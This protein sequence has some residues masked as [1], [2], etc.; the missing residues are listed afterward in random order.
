MVNRSL[1]PPISELL[2]F[3]SAARHRSFTRA[4]QE[5]CLTQGAISRSV[6]LLE[7]RMS[8]AL[9]ERIR[10]RVVLTG[11]GSSYLQ[12]IQPLLDDLGDATRRAMALAPS[13][14]RL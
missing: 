8:V 2:A 7:E 12:Q 11:A 10:Q 9:F 14:E 3:E 1:L 13:E 4:A 6:R 5:L